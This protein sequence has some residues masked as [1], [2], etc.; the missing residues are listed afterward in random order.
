MEARKVR[1]VGYVL[2]SVN[3]D[4]TLRFIGL[5][6]G[7]GPGSEST[8]YRHQGLEQQQAGGSPGAL[9]ATTGGGGAE[10]QPVAHL[11]AS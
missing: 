8:A 2:V 1:F 9:R 3:G 11:L 6:R 7:A 5:I 4:S 10:D